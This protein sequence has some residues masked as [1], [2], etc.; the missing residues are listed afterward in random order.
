MA[1]PL[2]NV[3]ASVLDVPMESLNEETSPD[4]TEE[5]DSLAAMHLVSAIEDAFA[6][7]L[8][9]RDIMRMTSIGIAREVLQTKGADV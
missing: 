5:W 7:R 1:D 3:F 4:N 6:V 8:G 2:L 9:T